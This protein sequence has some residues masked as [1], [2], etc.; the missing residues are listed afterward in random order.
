MKKRAQLNLKTLRIRLE[1]EVHFRNSHTEISLEK[2]DPLLIA[3]AYNDEYIALLCAL[4]SYGNVRAIIHFLR[5]LDFSLLHSN[6]EKIRDKL[7]VYYRFQT[8][9]DVQEIFITLSRLKQQNISLEALFHA[10]YQ[11]NNDVMQGLK[12]LI[13]YLYDTNSYRS[14]GYQFLLGNIAQSPYKSTYKR[15]HM[16]LR[17]MVRSDCLDLG[18]WRNIATQDLLVPLD[19]HTFTIGK[20]IGL[21]TQKSYDFKAVLELTNALKQFDPSDPVKYDFALYRIGQEKLFDKGY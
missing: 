8:V 20:K 5:S 6:E 14:K 1:E 12:S 2:P 7:H 15:W 4:F 19:V 16:Y 21:I 3:R 10:G 13:E 18:L 9:C 17:W 11:S